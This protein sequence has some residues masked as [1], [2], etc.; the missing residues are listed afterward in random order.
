MITSA[1]PMFEMGQ[2]YLPEFYVL[3]FCSSARQIPMRYAF[4][5]ASV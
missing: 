1:I 3:H 4:A 5:K 2:G